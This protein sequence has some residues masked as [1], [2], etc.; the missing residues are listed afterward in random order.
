MYSDRV[1][2][3]GVI[4]PHQGVELA[5]NASSNFKSGGIDGIV[6]LAFDQI[7]TV[8]PIQQR[9]FFSNALPSL[10]SKLFTAN[11]K[12]NAT[13]SYTFGYID[14]NQHNGPISYTPVDKSY[15]FWNFS[16]ESWS[17]GTTT[18]QRTLWGVADTGT[19]LLLVEDDVVFG[20]YAQVGSSYYDQTNAGIMFDCSE[21]LPDF[22][23]T[24]NGYNAV[25]PGSYM[26]WAD[27]GGGSQFPLSM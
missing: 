15:G 14:P 21:D 3:G 19:T 13:G 17:V 8:V 23:L 4:V 11:L 7:N 22:T 25:V 16:S 1:N 5:L 6:G 2:I 20:Y 27:F 24:I 18:T 10:Q 9:T 26:S 12:R